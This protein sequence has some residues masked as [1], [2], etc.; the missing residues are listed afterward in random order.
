MH[1]SIENLV[2]EDKKSNS[3]EISGIYETRP[4]NW[5]NQSP[6]LSMILDVS[7]LGQ[8]NWQKCLMC[9]MSPWGPT[10]Q[11]MVTIGKR[12]W[13]ESKYKSHWER[14]VSLGRCVPS[15]SQN[16]QTHNTQCQP[17]S[18]S[19]HT[20]RGARRVCKFECKS[21]DVAC[22]QC[23]HSHWHNRS[24][25]LA[26]CCAWRCASCV[27]GVWC[28]CQDGWV[29][30]R[31]R[32]NV[33]CVCVWVT[34]WA[35]MISLTLR[36]TVLRVCGRVIL[37]LT[38]LVLQNL[39]VLALHSLCCVR[40]QLQMRR[41]L[42]CVFCQ[43]GNFI[44]WN[45]KQKQT[46]FHH[47]LDTV[48]SWWKRMHAAFLDGQQN[49]VVVCWKDTCTFWKPLGFGLVVIRVCHAQALVVGHWGV[50]FAL[51]LSPQPCVQCLVLIQGTSVQFHS[52]QPSWKRINNLTAVGANW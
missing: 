45:I 24:H 15:I 27:N 12:P 14:G 5:P 38:S 42:Q 33:V 31:F 36:R 34:A 26:L 35:C 8:L 18:G 22:R 11:V 41:I 10:H 2:R 50:V 19:I 29:Q 52:R 23:E 25:L 37:F 46:R 30:V 32:H 6:R 49:Q 20:G 4:S 16:S 1:S 13:S 39:F 9:D 17:W 44:V 28:W 51:T 21:F 40:I 43:F 48:E 47:P 7:T 3:A